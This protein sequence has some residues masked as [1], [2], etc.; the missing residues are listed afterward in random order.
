VTIEPAGTGLNVV[1]RVRPAQS[2]EPTSLKAS[3]LPGSN[4][5]EL[6]GAMAAGGDA[7]VLNVSVDNPPRFFA[8]ALRNALVTGGIPVSGPAVD[9]EE[10]IEA[11]FAHDGTTLL[12]YRSPPLST[13]LLSPMKFSVNMYEETLLKTLGA[14]T[15][16]PTFEAGRAVVRSVLG[17]WN[18]PAGEILQLDGSGLSRYSYVTAGALVSVLV[19]VDRDARLRDQ[20]EA[21]L[22]VA[23]WD[24]TLAGRMAGTAAEGNVRA[25]TGSMAS[26]RT[27]AGYVT[28]PDGDRLAF[29][30]LANNFDV[31]GDMVNRVIDGI[32]ARLAEFTRR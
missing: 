12:V 19:H 9:A 29:A 28:T 5:I 31:P 27:L 24:G 20:F 4:Q 8:S 32:A 11:G 26:V 3:R 7:R 14:T 30:I 22:P 16:T 18:V 1:N 10:I 2:G 17:R 13:L 6:S 25:K 21:S 15:G 23:G